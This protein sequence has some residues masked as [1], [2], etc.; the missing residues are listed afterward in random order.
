MFPADEMDNT[1]NNEEKWVSKRKENH[2][3]PM[4]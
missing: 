4:K 1:L 2:C 3:Y